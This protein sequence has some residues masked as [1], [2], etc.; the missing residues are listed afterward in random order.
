MWGED[1]VTSLG[2]CRDVTGLFQ[3]RPET[4]PPGPPVTLRGCRPELAGTFD[5]GLVHVREDGT[6]H[7]MGQVVSG[8]VL[9]AGPSVL[10]AGLVDITTTARIN[11]PLAANDRP[12]WDLWRAGGPVELN[13]WAELDRSDRYLWVRAAAAHRIHTADKPEGTVYHLDG[14]HV[15][16]YDAFY[17]AIGEAINGPGGY[18]GGDAF[19]LHE[20]AATG[21]GGATPGFRLIWHDS[22]VARAHLVAG[23]DRKSWSSAVTFDDLVDWLTRDGVQLELR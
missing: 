10:G 3:E 11:G 12:L 18:F 4:W 22:A 19:W 23:Y 1:Q 6:A 20:N 15:T 5:A 14:R 9:A 2:E 8:T 7:P 21:D 13:Q 17:C 16:D